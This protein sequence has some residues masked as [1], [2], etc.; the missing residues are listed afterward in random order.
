MEDDLEYL[1]ERQ[2][3]SG[4]RRPQSRTAGAG[5]RIRSSGQKARGSIVG[6]PARTLTHHGQRYCLV[7]TYSLPD[8]AWILELHLARAAAGRDGA[9]GWHPG[10]C[11]VAVTVPDEDPDADPAISFWGGKDWDIPYAVMSWFMEAAEAEV[12][13]CRTAFNAEGA[14]A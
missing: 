13:M 7:S 5:R 1:T 9:A 3:Y 12:Q 10:D 11:F 8:A 2:R 14:G 6:M 4:P